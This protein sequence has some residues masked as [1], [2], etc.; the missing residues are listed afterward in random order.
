MVIVELNGGLGNQIDQYSVGRCLAYK[1]H[2]E[3]KLAL[4]G[5]SSNPRSHTCYKLGDFNIQEV[6][7]TPE[8]I[9][10]VREK[11]TT[12]ISSKDLENIQSD[13]F[14]RGHWMHDPQLYKSIGDIIRKEFTLKKPFNPNAEAWHKKIL[15]VECSVS[16]HF[17][18]GDYAYNPDRKGVQ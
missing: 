17:R 8:E 12:P 15:S 18:H 1:N 10:H 11:G 14:I 5:L 16:M 13:V 6:L 7:A 9:K 4:S 3:L 2:T